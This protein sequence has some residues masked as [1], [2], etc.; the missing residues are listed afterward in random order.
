M[1]WQSTRSPIASD[2]STGL[3]SLLRSWTM[4]RDRVQDTFPMQGNSLN[5]ATVL[6]LIFGARISFGNS[7]ALPFNLWLTLDHV[8]PAHF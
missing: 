5:D 2:N 6:A 4:T 1:L 8:K 3:L 7:P